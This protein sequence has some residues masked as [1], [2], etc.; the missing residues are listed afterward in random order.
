MMGTVTS[1]SAAG[2]QQHLHQHVSTKYTVVDLDN[3]E[4][5][6]QIG[7]YHQ[8]SEVITLACRR[9]DSF[10]YGSRPKRR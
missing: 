4:F 9:L 2:F 7:Q 1:T 6:P 8:P 5:G 3:V 10:V